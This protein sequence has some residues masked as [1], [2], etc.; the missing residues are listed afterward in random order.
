MPIF[1]LEIM[2]PIDERETQNEQTE[3]TKQ[4]NKDKKEQRVRKL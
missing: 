3:T 2:K 1:S 4:T